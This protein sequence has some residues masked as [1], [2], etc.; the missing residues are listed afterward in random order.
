MTKETYTRRHLSEGLLTVSVGESM[1]IMM[2]IMTT[3]RL[4][5]T[6]LGQ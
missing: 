4:A 5:G 2:E 1:T 6:T 3:G